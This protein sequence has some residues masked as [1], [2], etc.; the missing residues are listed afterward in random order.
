MRFGI[1]RLGMVITK[2]YRPLEEDAVI[3]ATLTELSTQLDDLRTEIRASGQASPALSLVH[4]DNAESATNLLHYLTLRSNDL[5]LL[6]HALSRWGLSS[7]GR[8]EAHVLPTVDLVRAALGAIEGEAPM[9]VEDSQEQ[10]DTGETQ[11]SRNSDALFG[12]RR[13][14]RAT[15]VMVTLP[16]EAAEDPSFVAECAARGSAIFRINTAHDDQSVWDAMIARIRSLPTGP[17]AR[18]FMDL[19]G[20]K[21]RTGPIA[22]GPEVVRL[23]PKRDAL[24]RP[25]SPAQVRLSTQ[26]DDDAAVPVTDQAWLLR[27]RLGDEV[28]FRDTRDSLRTMAVVAIGQGGVTCEL[29]DT[30]YL[31]TGTQLDV[32]GDVTE[33]GRLTAVE[34]RLRLHLADELILTADLSPTDPLGYPVRIGCSVP[35]VLD[36]VHVGERVYFDD[37]KLGGRVVATSPGQVHI[38]ITEC[39]ESGTWLRAEKGV[40]MPDSDLALASLTDDDRAVL[41]FIVGHADGVAMSLVNSAADIAALRGELAGLGAPDFPI[42]VKVETAR[43]FSQLPEILMEAL[44]SPR[45]GVMIA[46][47]DLAVEAGYARLGELQEEIMW[48]CE[49]AHV[50]VIWAT[51]VLETLAQTGRPSR[52]EV[53]DAALSVRSECVMLNKGPFILEAVSFLDDL[54]T[55]MADHVDK[56]SPLLRRLR[57]SAGRD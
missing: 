11:L 52:A 29:F 4:P 9:D 57:L 32:N 3:K 38:Q 15:R 54:L 45:I 16:T 43:A 14:G 21:L 6:Q 31:V 35:E 7:L 18:V 22:A 51:Q 42:I 36:H 37:G 26:A 30:G 13:F 47:G 12:A 1:E 39:A 55:R 48:L 23:R 40:N 8:C 25:S 20:P 44:R 5:R 33:V 46:R 17:P 50:P 34:Q 19:A 24:G 2:L 10:H 53:T 56:K 28:R 27:R 49:A 41:P